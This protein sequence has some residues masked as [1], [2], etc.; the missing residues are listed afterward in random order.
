M[1]VWRGAGPAGS[2][3]VGSRGGPPSKQPQ[4]DRRARQR[5]KT[6]GPMLTA[7]L[8]QASEASGLPRTS[9]TSVFPARLSA[10]DFYP[11][12][13]KGAQKDTA[14]FTLAPPPYFCC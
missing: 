6:M 4:A 7:P 9:V 3:E 8:P 1:R 5:P 14:S 13:R 2:L 12:K 10:R 11:S